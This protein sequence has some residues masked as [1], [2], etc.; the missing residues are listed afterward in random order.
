MSKTQNPN[1]V[2]VPF[3]EVQKLTL[4]DAIACAVEQQM[5]AASAYVTTAK[6]VLHMETLTIPKGK[7]IGGLL[8][9]AGVKKSNIDNARYAASVFTELV[10]TGLLPEGEFDKLTFGECFRIRRAM[11]S[12]SELQLSGPMVVALLQESD[13]ADEELDCFYEHGCDLAKKTKQDKA[14]ADAEKARAEAAKA[15]EIKAAAEKLA[16]EKIAAKQPAANTP[17]S[18]F[19]G[20]APAAY[21]PKTGAAMPPSGSVTPPP[22]RASNIVPMQSDAPSA[23][24]LRNL[25]NELADLFVMVAEADPAEARKAWPFIQDTVN[26]MA[27][28]IAEIP[29]P[30]P[31]P[32]PTI[33]KRP[34]TPA[35]TGKASKTALAGAVG[36]V[37]GGKKAA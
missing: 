27:E 11:S 30:E 10:A 2:S 7:T 29:A 35:S 9:E 17:P 8:R 3:S 13:R 12:G 20:P 28:M 25:V 32:L 36:K 18:P 22:V 26:T 21:A 14:A 1:P 23:D 16:A 37:L 15:A 4:K 19:T 33:V 6:L 34:S 5:K 31:V 24:D